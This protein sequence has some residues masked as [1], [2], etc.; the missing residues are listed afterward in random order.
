MKDFIMAAF[1]LV[2]MGIGLAIFAV[3]DGKRR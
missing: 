1:P 3:R 2:L